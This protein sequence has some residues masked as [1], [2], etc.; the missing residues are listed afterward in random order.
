[1]AIDSFKDS[2]VQISSGESKT[3]FD[4]QFGAKKRD[5]V[6][7]EKTFARW[8]K[9]QKKAECA[10]NQQGLGVGGA[11]ASIGVRL[12]VQGDPSQDLELKIDPNWRGVISNK[13]IASASLQFQTSAVRGSADL[14]PGQGSSS[15]LDRREHVDATVGTALTPDYRRG[16]STTELFVPSDD[17]S[18]GDIVRAAVSADV[19]ASVTKAVG[20]GRADAASNNDSNYDGRILFGSVQVDWR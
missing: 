2:P 15:I 20:Q 14:F 16:T 13:G 9:D 10:V 5:G 17:L 3:V 4:A 19:T 7:V 1:M 18:D 12:E 8:T 6:P 11:S